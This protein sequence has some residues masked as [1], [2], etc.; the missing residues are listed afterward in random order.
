MNDTI[1]LG[2]LESLDLIQE[3]SMDA[4]VS[5]MEALFN[6]Y[7]KL[8]INIYNSEESVFMEGEIWDTATGKGK[9][10]SDLWKILA[11]LPRLLKGIVNA[12]TSVFTKDNQ[13]QIAKNLEN[14]NKYTETELA[15]RAQAFN[16]QTNGDVQFDPKKKQ[17]FLGK[18]FRHIRNSIEICVGLLPLFKKITI[19]LKGGNTELTTL[20]NEVI[21]VLKGQKKFDAETMYLSL[22]AAKNLLA[23]SWGAAIGIRGVTDELS[24]LIENKLRK[25]YKK[26]GAVNQDKAK[27]KALLDQ[28]SEGSKHVAS[29]TS[30][31]KMMTIGTKVFGGPIQRW[32][33]KHSVNE[34][35]IE[36]ND[37]NITKKELKTRLKAL[38]AE[39]RTIKADKKHKDEL[40][41]EI[42]E[43]E[44]KINKKKDQIVSAK[45]DRDAVKAL[46]EASDKAWR[47][48]MPD[49][50]KRH[51]K[52]GH[53]KIM[54]AG[55][56]ED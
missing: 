21:S 23:D 3:S 7:E 54:P 48:E 30:F 37:A 44:E 18:T 43:L 12:M 25:D 26:T 46:D 16:Q 34:E 5:V 51:E 35:D 55:L 20:T 56:K 2:I 19:A 13:T 4:S 15:Q 36:L 40:R 50:S 38:K 11:F 28:V 27:L 1:S 42:L 49:G 24:M 31:F 29:V 10:E 17:F 22:D 14:V 52:V 39:Y 45:E 47:E 32:M 53:H 6:E 8:S 41:D 9:A 33:N